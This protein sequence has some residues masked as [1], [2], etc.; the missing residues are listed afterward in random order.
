MKSL[1]KDV[2]SK[3]ATGANTA[4]ADMALQQLL[5]ESHI[6]GN[7]GYPMTSE[8]RLNIDIPAKKSPIRRPA[9]GKSPVMLRK[10]SPH[11][12]SGY[13]N[14]LTWGTTASAAYGTHMSTSQ[15]SCSFRVQHRVGN[16]EKV[17][18]LGSIPQLDKWSW[19]GPHSHTLKW[20]QGDVWVSPVPLLTTQYFFHYKYAVVNKD[21]HVVRWERGVDRCADFEIMPDTKMSGDYTNP[22]DYFYQMELNGDTPSGSIKH[23][24]M[25]EEWEKFWVSF[26]IY[27]VNEDPYDEFFFDC[28]KV[29]AHQ[30]PMS[31]MPREFVWMS[32]KY[33]RNIRPW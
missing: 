25:N 33:G 31:P 1:R 32:P 24:Q 19:D 2:P 7:H 4:V 5:D 22:T 11:M 28:K 3:K 16:D 20:T 12:A 9:G 21:D 27:D 14:K 13:S 23:L 10:S 6:T 8:P 30:M 17:V 18:V 29:N 26:M 15:Y